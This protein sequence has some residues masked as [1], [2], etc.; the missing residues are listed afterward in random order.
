M[1][2]KNLSHWETLEHDETRGYQIL[3]HEVEGGWEIEVRFDDERAPRRP[4][5][6]PATRGEAIKTGQELAKVG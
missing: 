3:G 5:S 4:E 2:K 1:A 6:K